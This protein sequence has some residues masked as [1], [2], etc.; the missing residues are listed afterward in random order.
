LINP[1]I[2]VR[3]IHYASS[4][5][6][7]GIIFFDLFIAS[8][9]L[10][11]DPRWQTSERSF[12]KAADKT[13]WI[14]LALSIATAF[15]WLVLL[16]ARIADKPWDEAIA[17]GT[18]WTVLSRTQFGFAWQARLLLAAALAA[19]LLWQ[20]K[21]G[22]GHAAAA[23]RILASLLAAAYLGSLA[24]AGHGAKGLSFERN[25][26]LTAD[27][28]HMIAAGL[29]IGGLAPFVLLLSRLRRLG[30]QGWV[31]IAA[32]AGSRFS[33]FGILAVGLLL[34]SGT[35]NASFLLAG[36]H[37]L[38]DTSYGRLLLLKLVLFAAM[39]CLAGI[40]RQY[41]LPRLR[42]DAGFKGSFRTVHRLVGNSLAELALGVAIVLIVG[43]LG[44]MAP[45]NEMAAH[46][47]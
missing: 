15:A 1:L 16:A 21:A 12:R 6:V 5:I 10:R 2:I 23:V 28:L 33:T 44:V 41:L 29:W 11:S 14:S 39:L 45:A 27:A 4:M 7:A 20:R 46:I 25:I 26:H 13:L 19:C 37:S 9:I 3:D 42:D 24:F 18:L 32:A 38:I 22:A 47:H 8:P 17:D 40:N 36:M 43:A 30:E 35:I 31:S 34:V